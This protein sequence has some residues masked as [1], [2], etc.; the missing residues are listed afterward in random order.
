MVGSVTFITK[1]VCGIT[2]AL[3][4][5]RATHANTVLVIP[6]ITLVTADGLSSKI[7]I[8]MAVTTW[9]Y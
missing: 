2:Q 4:G 5:G 8:F 1:P 7:Y 3:I 9:A 6:D